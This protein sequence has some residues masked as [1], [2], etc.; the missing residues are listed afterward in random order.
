SP[1]ELVEVSGDQ[2]FEKKRV[3]SEIYTSWRNNRLQFNNTKLSEL[4][5]ILKENYG[6]E[7]ILADDGLRNREFTAVYPADD[8]GVLFKAL[9]KSFDLKVER[10]GDTIILRSMPSERENSED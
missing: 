5:I 3:E 6:L 8:L 10:R 2:N 1:G 9:A 4:V 7:V